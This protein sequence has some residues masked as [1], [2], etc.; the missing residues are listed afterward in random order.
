M[1]A[2]KQIAKAGLPAALLIAGLSASATA[3]EPTRAIARLV[4]QEG[5]PA[6]TVDFTRAP[7]GVL[8]EVQVFGLTPGVHAIHLHETGACMPDFS[9][10]GGHL[11]PDGKTHGFLSPDGPHAGDLPEITVGADGAAAA[12]F[13]NTLVTLDDGPAGLLDAD[14]SAVIVHEH[15]DTHSDTADFGEAI[16]CGV[17]TI[18]G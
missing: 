6:G 10:A 15:G 1:F 5:T 12:Q 16:A 4:T 18:I 9:A 2:A 14:G 7:T 8:I 13:F 3:Q 17:I 11:N